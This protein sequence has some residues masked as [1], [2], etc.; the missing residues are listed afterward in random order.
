MDPKKLGPDDLMQ[1]EGEGSRTAA[2]DY[3]ERTREFE[4]THPDAQELAQDA[5]RDVADHPEEFARAEREGK[6]RAAGEDPL[7]YEKGNPQ[8]P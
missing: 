8:D 5:A 7:L 3:E 6:A 1:N 2:K 4:R